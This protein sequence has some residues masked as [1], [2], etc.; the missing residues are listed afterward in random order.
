VRVIGASRK[1]P[2]AFSIAAAVRS[3]D[4]GMAVEQSMTMAPGL[5]PSSRPS[6]RYSTSS[7]SGVPVTHR[8]MIS[9]AAAS[10]AALAVVL[11]PA[12]SSSSRG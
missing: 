10:D 6:F 2:P 3:V 5:M 12:A 4:D 1:R 11:A 7:T 9:T 8:I